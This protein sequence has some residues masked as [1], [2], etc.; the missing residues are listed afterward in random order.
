MSGAE[1]FLKHLRSTHF[2]LVITSLV[3]LIG[4]SNA[5]EI[6]DR[7]L[8]Q[9]DDIVEAP[10]VFEPDS[11]VVRIR[12]QAG[13][14]L[15]ESPSYESDNLEGYLKSAV[16]EYFGWSNLPQVN[17][18]RIDVTDLAGEEWFL[19]SD[20][21]V[22]D[23]S[24]F[25]YSHGAILQSGDSRSYYLLQ[26]DGLSVESLAG[27][28][29]SLN[30]LLAYDEL[31]H[32]P[33]YFPHYDEATLFDDAGSKIAPDDLAETI[34]LL[35]EP[36][37]YAELT[38][39]RLTT[40]ED[41]LTYASAAEA[42]NESPEAWYRESF[43]P[44]FFVLNARVRDQSL[45]FSERNSSAIRFTLHLPAFFRVEQPEFLGDIL[46]N[47]FPE[48]RYYARYLS[49]ARS[50]AELFPELDELTLDLKTLGMKDLRSYLR[51]EASEG[52]GPV[53]VVGIEVKQ[54]MIEIWGFLVLLGVQAYFSLHYR[55]Y[56][57]RY[58]SEQSVEFPWIGVYHDRASQLFFRSSLALPVVTC[59]YLGWRQYQSAGAIEP[60]TFVYGLAAF[61]IFSGVWI[62]MRASSK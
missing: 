39:V 7:A 43:T 35:E 29:S 51:R 41:R 1:D 32:S 16:D 11:L 14:L 37:F 52:D 30:A 4:L 8:E 31:F 59:V 10:E 22:L 2:V 24:S 60:L 58:G 42:A 53:S 33:Q 49:D 23:D 21:T 19:E 27:A 6:Y 36:V 62:A 28:A 13:A 56:L 34:E 5:S 47:E 45:S 50:F 54:N 46:K 57:Q 26:E 15:S 18:E 48:R 17:F 61:G 40:D 20:E 12:E 55:T 9:L 38:E 3:I 44:D 25:F